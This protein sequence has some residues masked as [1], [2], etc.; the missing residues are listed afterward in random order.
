MVQVI[1]VIIAHG[2]L[3]ESVARQF[4]RQIVMAMSYCHSLNVIHRDLKPEN[5]L[6]DHQFRIKII[7]FGLSNYVKEGGL[8]KTFCG[9][10]TYTAPELILQ[11]PYLGIPPFPSTPLFYGS[12]AIS[13]SWL[14]S[15][16]FLH[17]LIEWIGP[18]IDVWSLGVVLFVLVCGYLPFD[19]QNFQELFQKITAGEFAIP[20]FLSDECVCLI[21]RMLVVDPTKRA[22]LEE[23][24][25][26]IPPF[27]VFCDPNENFV[28]EFAF[29]RLHRKTFFWAHWACLGLVHFFCARSAPQKNCF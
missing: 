24:C 25:S 13:K 12:R 10:P 28:C 29:G 22:T 27:C 21:K 8:L 4:F 6:L 11:Q 7:D 20:P 5:L 17:G 16:I 3:K 23:V 2:K 15:L 14:A 26:P 18:G 9:S 19:G 1:D